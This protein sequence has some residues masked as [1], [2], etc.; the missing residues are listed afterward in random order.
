MK[1]ETASP[2]MHVYLLRH[3]IAEEGRIG[4]NDAERALTPDGRRKLRHV[5]K[6]VAEARVKPSLVLSSHL[7]RAVQTAE[8]RKGRARLCR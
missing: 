7:K 6:A 8:I 2:F 5:L 1:G 3:G 4:Q